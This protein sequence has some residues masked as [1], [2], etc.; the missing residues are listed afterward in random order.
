MNDV[1]YALL[2]PS[3]RAKFIIDELSALLAGQTVAPVVIDNEAVEDPISFQLEKQLESF[4]VDNWASTELGQKYDI[5]TVD[6]EQVGHQYQTETGP[7]DILAISKDKKELL[8]V[9]LK[10]GRA[11]DRVVGQ[12]QRYMGFVVKNLAE[13]GQTVKGAIIALEDDARVQLALLVAPNISFYTYQ[14][15]FKLKQ[16]GGG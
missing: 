6:G 9:E 3:D 16:M 2:D 8:V 4:L 10:R 15:S 12:V 11:S 5:Y 7:L 1:E 14:I 13:D